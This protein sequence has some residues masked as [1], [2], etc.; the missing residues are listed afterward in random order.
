MH[1]LD[2]G[3]R[4]PCTCY[5]YAEGLSGARELGRRCVIKDSGHQQLLAW[6]V[7]CNE[8]EAIKRIFRRG[9]H[10]LPVEWKYGRKDRQIQ[11]REREGG[12][13]GIGIP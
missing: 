3:I 4:W 2:G 8:I 7:T 11:I 13:Y 6:F 12:N 5:V 1:S 10:S 9:V